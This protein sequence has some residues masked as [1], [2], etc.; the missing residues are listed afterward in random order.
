[1]KKPPVKKTASKSNILVE[2]TDSDDQAVN[3]KEIQKKLKRLDM[4]IAKTE[5][6]IKLYKTKLSEALDISKKEKALVETGLRVLKIKKN[7][8]FEA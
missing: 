4:Y 1:M 5:H 8:M 3:A 2:F 6:R 7:Q